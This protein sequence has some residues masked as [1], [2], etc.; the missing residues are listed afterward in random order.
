MIDTFPQE[1]PG[2]TAIPRTMRCCFLPFLPGGVPWGADVGV[3]FDFFQFLLKKSPLFF[4][5]SDRVKEP[6]VNDDTAYLVGNG[7]KGTDFLGGERTRFPRLNDNN[8]GRAFVFEEGKA[9]ERKKAFFFCFSKVFIA[10]VCGGI[11]GCNY[12]PL[13]NNKAGQ[14]F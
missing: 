2:E 4:L 6:C 1:K 7:C 11:V 5:F 14:T 10:R 3:G 8:A 13:F 12:F 9:E